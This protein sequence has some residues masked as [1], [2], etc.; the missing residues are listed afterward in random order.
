MAIRET[1]DSGSALVAVVWSQPQYV[2]LPAGNAGL[3]NRPDPLKIL[4]VRHFDGACACMALPPPVRAAFSGGLERNVVLQHAPALHL[5]TPHQ[6]DARPAVE[7]GHQRSVGGPAFNVVRCLT[8]RAERARNRR[9][10]GHS[11]CCTWLDDH[12]RCEEDGTSVERQS[13][14]RTDRLK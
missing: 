11:A 5:G 7:E 13:D 8:R 12:T 6:A 10:G 4:V 2:T 14:Y 1:E 9:G 3:G